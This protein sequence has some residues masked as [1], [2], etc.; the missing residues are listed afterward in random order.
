MYTIIFHLFTCFVLLNSL[1]EIITKKHR[2]APDLNPRN[3]AESRMSMKSIKTFTYLFGALLIF[4]RIAGLWMPEKTWFIILLI[5]SF[6]AMV[7][8]I[9]ATNKKARWGV[10]MVSYIIDV[11]CIGFIIYLYYVPLYLK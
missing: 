11:I 1:Y 2:K 9:L 7:L 10:T 3:L 8:H 5:S 6:T 4:W